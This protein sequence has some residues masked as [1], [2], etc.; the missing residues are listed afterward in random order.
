[1]SSFSQDL[2][3]CITMYL[4]GRRRYLLTGLQLFYPLNHST[5][6]AEFTP[7]SCFYLILQ[8]MSGLEAGQLAKS[9]QRVNHEM[10]Q[11]DFWR[12]VKVVGFN[13]FLRVKMATIRRITLVMFKKM[14]LALM[15]LIMIILMQSW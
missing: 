14:D 12:S 6:V 10:V 11:D 15:F 5:L 7:Q 3:H 2:N 8:I 13:R 9:L 1:M 4:L